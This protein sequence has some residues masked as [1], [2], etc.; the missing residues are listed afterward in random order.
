MRVGHEKRG[1]SGAL[2]A[3]SARERLPT[4]VYCR[5][6]AAAP[7]ASRCAPRAATGTGKQFFPQVGVWP[8]RLEAHLVACA[9]ELSQSWLGGLVAVGSPPATQ[10]ASTVP[11]RKT[12][13]NAEENDVAI[14]FKMPKSQDARSGNFS[15]FRRSVLGNDS[16][17]RLKNVGLRN[18]VMKPNFF[19][20]VKSNHRDSS[21]E[22]KTQSDT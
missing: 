5:A 17:N 20:P 2:R 13:S 11:R 1:V 10:P 21:L 14:T 9:R 19:T 3:P 18:D 4:R 12:A 8:H 22:S 6:S 16:S 15:R 7:R